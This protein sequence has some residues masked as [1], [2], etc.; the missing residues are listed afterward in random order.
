MEHTPCLICGCEKSRAAYTW[1]CPYEGFP[2]S[3]SIAR[4]N[5]CGFLFTNPRLSQSAL[6]EYYAMVNPYSKECYHPDDVFRPRY[7]RLIKALAR[8]GCTGGR[9]LEIGCDKG[10]FLSVAEEKG[11]SVEGVEPSASAETARR[12]H[13]L[14]VHTGRF[15]NVDF[16]EKM[17]DCIVLLDVLE[18][19]H[20]PLACL[21]KARRI[22]SPNGLALIKVPNA[23]HERGIYPFLRG[24]A[25]LGFGAHEHLSHFSKD[26]LTDALKRADMEIAA[27][28]GFVPLPGKGIARTIMGSA[29]L[30]IGAA[31]ARVWKNWPDYHVSLVCL[32][33]GRR[34]EDDR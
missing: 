18:H 23:R 13:G 20:D 31:L 5:A 2:K 34:R 22:L 15:E 26:T 10:Q 6:D 4:C 9:L 29:A 11:F 12:K 14:K 17:F 24:K 21:L 25:A 3:F 16:Q 33:R 1:N 19:F 27:W 28:L 7:E 32:A 8:H 30:L